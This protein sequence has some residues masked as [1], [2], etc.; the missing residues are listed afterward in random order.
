[1]KITVIDFE[2]AGMESYPIEFGWATVDIDAQEISV[3]SFLIRP[4]EDWLQNWEWTSEAELLHGL[5]LRDLMDKGINVETAVQ[6]IDER[7][8]DTPLYSD[9][10]SFEKFWM[11]TLY[12]AAGTPRPNRTGDIL[13]LQDRLEEIVKDK[14]LLELEFAMRRRTHRRHRAGPDALE[15]GKL[16]ARIA[17]PDQSFCV[18]GIA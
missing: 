2:A 8:G 6:R 7:F 14:P 13:K 4:T 12:E 15:W 17:C 16:V 1:M 3:D 11:K 10:P 18:T 9:A 5:R